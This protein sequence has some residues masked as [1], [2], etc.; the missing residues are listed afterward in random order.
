[1]PFT[2]VICSV[3]RE[4]GAGKGGIVPVP[5]YLCYSLKGRTLGLQRVQKYATGTMW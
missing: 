4:R 3:G 1:M 2:G 5:S